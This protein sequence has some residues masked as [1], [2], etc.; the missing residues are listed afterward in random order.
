MQQEENLTGNP[1]LQLGG[2]LD[3]WPSEDDGVQ[4]VQ[5]VLSHRVEDGRVL[6]ECW[7]SGGE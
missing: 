6:I 1:N 2:L 4:I 3:P 5:E 7:T